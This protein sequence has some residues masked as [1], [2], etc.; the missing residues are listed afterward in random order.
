M[1][2]IFW[3]YTPIF[4]V[5]WLSATSEASLPQLGETDELRRL[6][7]SDVDRGRARFFPS[8]ERWSFVGPDHA[9]R[10]GRNGTPLDPVTMEKTVVRS[11]QSP[12]REVSGPDPA[13]GFEAALRKSLGDRKDYSGV[14]FVSSGA[15]GGTKVTAGG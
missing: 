6:T 13:I 14:A 12:V 3:T 4:L 15:R 2:C 8:L 9:I 5:F 1:R 11:I 10:Q 7:Y